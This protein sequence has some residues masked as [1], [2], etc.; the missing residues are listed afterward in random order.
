MSKLWSHPLIFG[1]LCGA[2]P[3]AAAQTQVSLSEQSKSIDLSNLGPTKPMQTGTVLPA[4]CS[5]GQMFFLTTAAPGSNLYACT[6][7]N[8]WTGIV[9][10]GSGGGSGGSFAAGT[11]IVLTQ[12][13]SSTTL[14]VDTALIPTKSVVQATTSNIVTL[15]STSPSTLTGTG[16]PTLG[17]YSDKQLIEF[18]WN[19]ACAGGAMTIAI[20]GLSAVNLVKSDGST[21][22]TTADCASG[23]TNL[24]SYDG[25]LGKFK[26]MGGGA[27]SSGGSGGGSV[28]FS[29]PYMVSG[30]NSYLPFGFQ[31]T[32]P[33]TTGWTA[34][35][36]ESGV[37][38]TSGLGGAINLLSG[39]GHQSLSIEGQVIGS[40]TTLTA[41]IGI[42]G[43]VSNSNSKYC[44]V[45][46]LQGSN[47]NIYGPVLIGNGNA[48]PLQLNV[49]KWS[50]PTNVGGPELPSASIPMI[51]PIIWMK[52]NIS[53]GNVVTSYSNDGFA[54]SYQL[55]SQT[56]SS[57]FGTS[58]VST[59]R[60]GIF[61]DGDGTN[62]TSC[63]VYSWRA[64]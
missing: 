59:D 40:T 20:D 12:S 25:T 23:Q 48:T 9:G 33:P 27:V 43:N 5:S 39:T 3:F 51:G 41:V 13:G 44:A 29:P 36:L 58:I 64:Q 42:A 52:V 7:T 60:W 11:G 61:S 34:T 19:V 37:F 6:A 4:V 38:T 10:S 63:T 32:L 21:T 15:T 8:I 1:L 30:G 28:T 17:A 56:Q 26:L 18:T 55:I 31:A 46:I 14:S 62:T 54:T 2:C 16:N 22:L 24:F 57:L 50:L 49:Y 53:G 47:P 45:G 35:N